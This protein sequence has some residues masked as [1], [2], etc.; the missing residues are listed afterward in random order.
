M[1]CVVLFLILFI[2]AHSFPSVVVGFEHDGEMRTGEDGVALKV[3]SPSRGL[4]GFLQL[5]GAPFES[6]VVT[7]FLKVIMLG[8]FGL[9]CFYLSIV[10]LRRS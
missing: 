5:L 7:A 4:F 1:Q 10:K 3:R 2:G 8:L 6:D 9:A